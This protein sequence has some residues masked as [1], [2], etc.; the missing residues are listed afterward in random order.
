[1][2]KLC[3]N[4]KALYHYRLIIKINKRIVGKRIA[5]SSGDLVVFCRVLGIYL[6]NFWGKYHSPMIKML[7]TSETG[8]Q[9]EKLQSGA[10]SN[11]GWTVPRL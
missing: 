3:I 11:T 1:M 4:D 10:D 5:S 6:N 8:T 2:E 7:T 9:Y